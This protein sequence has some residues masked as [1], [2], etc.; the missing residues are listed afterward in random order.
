MYPIRS[1]NPIGFLEK[2]HL[3][4][5]THAT[6]NHTNT[7]H[8]SQIHSQHTHTNTRLLLRTKHIHGPRSI[9]PN[10]QQQV[11]NEVHTL[12]SVRSVA[13]S[14]V[15]SL[16]LSVAASSLVRNLCC[17][18][19]TRSI[20]DLLLRVCGHRFTAKC[21]RFSFCCSKTRTKFEFYCSKTR[22]ARSA[23]CCCSKTR[24]LFCCSKT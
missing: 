7:Q 18:L 24:S 16:L 20:P 8:K 13:N 14:F 23:F 4:T 21:H 9:T 6:H 22:I 12:R 15:C 10:G 1:K 3:N 2:K 19:R 5:Y 17:L 11:A